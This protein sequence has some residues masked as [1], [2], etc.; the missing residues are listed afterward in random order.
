MANEKPIMFDKEV[1]DFFG[2]SVRTFKRRILKP[3]P[4]EIN[5]NEAAPV[6][7]GRRR[8]WLRANI[9]RLV[10]IKKGTEK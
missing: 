9:E 3:V 5:P 4:G 8:I 2:I 6:T 1:A 7:I 10:G